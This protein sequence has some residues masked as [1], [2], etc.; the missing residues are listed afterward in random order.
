VVAGFTREIV[1][2]VLELLFEARHRAM[3]KQEYDA[4]VSAA[5]RTIVPRMQAQ[6]LMGMVHKRCEDLLVRLL[7]ETILKRLLAGR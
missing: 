4:I 1:E 6:L 2:D 7:S 5:T 3:V